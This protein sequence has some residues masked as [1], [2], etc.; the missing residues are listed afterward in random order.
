ME[1]SDMY[2]VFKQDCIKLVGVF[3]NQFYACVVLIEQM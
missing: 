2:T 3:Q 1:K